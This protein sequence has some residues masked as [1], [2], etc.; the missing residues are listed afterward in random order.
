MNSI[1][2][3]DGLPSWWDQIVRNVSKK[4]G[5]YQ[6]IPT[7]LINDTVETDGRFLLYTMTSQYLTSLSSI[8]SNVRF[9]N[10]SS[11]IKSTLPKENTSRRNIFWVACGPTTE[12]QIL[13]S[14]HKIGL[15]VQN[16]S[17]GNH[18]K[19]NESDVI[20][21]VPVALELANSI[22]HEKESN[23]YGD[24]LKSVYKRFCSSIKAKRKNSSDDD[25]SKANQFDGT[26]V[27][28]DD[29]SYLTQLFGATFVMTFIQKLKHEL[30]RSIS[31]GIL[32]IRSRID[33]SI[34][35]A[36]LLEFD[37]SHQ[38]QNKN[39][40][41]TNTRKNVSGLNHHFPNSASTSTWLGAGG[42]NHIVSEHSH[43]A[44]FPQPRILG[45]SILLEVANAVVDV[46][47]LS[48]GFAREV[49]GRLVFSERFSGEIGWNNIRNDNP[50]S[51]SRSNRQNQEIQRQR[52]VFQRNGSIRNVPQIAKIKID[53]NIVN[54]VC[55]DQGVKVIR[56]RS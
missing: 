20:K 11:N 13:T 53:S 41:N 25:L 39:R 4:Y 24:Y 21:I 51:T 30:Q 46:L 29:V 16:P 44:Q 35:N 55:G 12:R 56:L 7:I 1:P 52:D 26:L 22:L 3:T 42:G 54:Y 28:I 32:I 34:H 27:I 6:F 23:I 48:S 31:G 33:L 15:D 17:H 19:K 38:I 50:S 8:S 47:P 49:H 45:Q 18:A 14:L 40:N 43:Y 36:H 5:D 10:H 9:K 2:L 37:W